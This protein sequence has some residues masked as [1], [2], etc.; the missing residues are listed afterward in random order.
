MEYSQPKPKVSKQSRGRPFGSWTKTVTNFKDR[1]QKH[2]YKHRE[3]IGKRR[4]QVYAARKAAGLCVTCGAARAKKDKLF[5]KAHR[6]YPTILHEVV[7][8]LTGRS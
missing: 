3:E 6:K 2:Y 1:F 8:H 5:C 4:A 7:E